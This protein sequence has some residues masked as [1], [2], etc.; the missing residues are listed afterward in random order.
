GEL[1][2]AA[3]GKREARRPSS[4]LEAG[5][6]RRALVRIVR[7]ARRDEPH[8]PPVERRARRR[9]VEDRRVD[10]V[11]YHP[12]LAELEPERAAGVERIARLEDGHVG[13][14]EV[15]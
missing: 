14:L 6:G 3:K 10:R 4:E 7:P 1:R 12:R 8:R 9:R 13:E 5:E 11:R 15:D 2:A